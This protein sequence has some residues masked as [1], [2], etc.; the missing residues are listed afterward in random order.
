MKCSLSG[1]RRR[2]W[3]DLRVPPGGAGGAMAENQRSA[4]QALTLRDSVGN[5]ARL[6]GDS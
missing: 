1:G 4:L 2:L 5:R 6:R 3:E